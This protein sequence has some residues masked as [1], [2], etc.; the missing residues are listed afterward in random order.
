MNSFCPLK[1]LFRLF[2]GSP[3]PRCPLRAA[4]ALSPFPGPFSPGRHTRTRLL[5]FRHAL[6]LPCFPHPSAPE[7]G[8]AAACVCPS[9]CH[10][11][12]TAPSL[13]SSAKL[14]PWP[15]T[16]LKA[17]SPTA[18]PPS[19]ISKPGNRASFSGSKSTLQSVWHKNGARLL[20]SG[21]LQGWISPHS[22]IA[23]S[24]RRFVGGIKSFP[25][26]CINQNPLAL[27]IIVGTERCLEQM[28][29]ELGREKS[30]CIWRA[31]GE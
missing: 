25:F 26:I 6:T 23:A 20:L 9:L 13:L 17:R 21:F 18:L 8:S 31:K 3:H 30:V 1:L 2:L 22:H 4:A 11:R 7:P 15:P 10:P 24:Q 14:T 16:P 28:C 5:V 27:L 19:R 29:Q 12:Y